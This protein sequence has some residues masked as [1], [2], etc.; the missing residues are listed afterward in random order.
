VISNRQLWADAW[1]ARD[2]LYRGLFGDYAAA[3]PGDYRAPSRDPAAAT[4]TS[5]P[6]GS[7]Q[8]E[9]E[10]ETL[11]V[12]AYAP[13]PLRPYWTYITAGLSSPWHQ[14][15]PQEVS[16]FGLEMMIKSP[17]QASWPARVLRSMAFYL[18]NYA[19][20]LSP[21]ALVAL[22]SSIDPDGDSQLK[23]IFVWYADEAPDCW[24]ELPSGGFGI[25]AATGITDDELRFAESIENYGAWSIQEVLRQA[26]VGQVTDPGRSSVME[27]QDIKSILGS[28]RMFANNFREFARGA[29][30]PELSEND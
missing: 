22:N 10:D 9:D 1:Q 29:Q 2:D 7:R 3:T 19:G 26:G 24:Y 4:R 17:V 23:N 15:V 20:T 8:P 14:E 21:G 28:V 27:R 13:D 18:F 30:D 5:D 16:G 6:G 12:L 25:F 11:A